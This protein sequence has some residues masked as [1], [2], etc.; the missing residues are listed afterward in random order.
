MARFLFTP[1]PFTGHVNP[2]LP[3]AQ[4]L[5]RRGHEVRWYTTPRFRD[6]V[7]AVGAHYVP[8]RAAPL[9]D[10]ERLDEMFPERSRLKGLAQLKYDLKHVFIDPVPAMFQ[11][12]DEEMAEW[13]ADVIVGDNCSGVAAMLSESH[14]TPWAVFGI[15]VMLF[16]SIDTAP[17]GTALLPKEGPMGRLRNRLLQGLTDKVLFRDVTAHLGRMRTSLG[18]RS[19]DRAMFDF[20]KDADLYLQMGVP[21]FEY[22]RSDLPDSVRFIGAPMPATPAGWSRPAW[23]SE[24]NSGRKVVLVTQG[25]IAND[26]DDLIRPAIHALAREDA[27]VIV[28]TG[29][30]PPEAVG[31]DP[32]PS[33][34]RVEQFVPY[35]HLMPRVDLLVTNGGFGSVMIALRHGVPVRS[36]RSQTA[37]S[38]RAPAL[39]SKFGAL[40]R[41]KSATAC[42][43]YWA[44]LG[45]EAAR[46]RWRTN[47]P[48]TTPPA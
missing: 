14:G 7:E 40:R 9:I 47:S 41:R 26:Y 5:T 8:Y 17:F 16:S 19:G 20:T 42:G 38:G 18:F 28:T 46:K 27:L 30:K 15:S 3:I 36:R 4:E 12:L 24:L 1:M 37:S 6:K 43:K 35:A 29:S 48:S 33:N 34:V 22:P 13:P 31:I 10:E 23:W 45:S 32:L 39:A 11:D 2:G 44:T 21:S 25:T